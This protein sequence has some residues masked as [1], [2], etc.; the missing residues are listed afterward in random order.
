MVCTSIYKEMDRYWW[1]RSLDSSIFTL[2]WILVLKFSKWME[3]CSWDR[4]HGHNKST[5]MKLILGWIVPYIHCK[6]N[7]KIDSAL[8]VRAYCCIIHEDFWRWEVMTSKCQI[9]NF[10][11]NL[12]LWG[13]LLLKRAASCNRA[14][15]SSAQFRTFHR[16]CHIYASLFG[17]RK[18]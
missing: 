3:W 4:H 9:K 16:I 18:W 15:P 5:A 8:S 13:A 11:G 2:I 17:C 10:P 12:S 6:T 7:C 1:Y 14:L